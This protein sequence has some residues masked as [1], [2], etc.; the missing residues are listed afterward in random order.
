MTPGERMLWCAVYAEYLRHP[1][2]SLELGH[3]PR[4][5]IVLAAAARAAEAVIELREMA[6]N[7]DLVRE[8]MR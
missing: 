4:E 2:P 7:A 6:G 5:R 8:V 1:A 3:A